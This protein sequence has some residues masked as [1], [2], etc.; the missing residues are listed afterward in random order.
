MGGK[1]VALRSFS[2]DGPVGYARSSGISI[3]IAFKWKSNHERSET[4]QKKTIRSTGRVAESG[5][6]ID[7]AI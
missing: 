2:S 6:R 4:T 7:Q 3:V 1:F 5:S